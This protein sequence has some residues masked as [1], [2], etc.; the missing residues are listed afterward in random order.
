MKQ[1]HHRFRL[2]SLKTD[3]ASPTVPE[4]DISQAGFTI[5]ELLIA[6]LV[7][8]M[9]II[10]ILYGVLDFT[11]AYYSGV[12]S[13]STQDTAR[14]IMNTI[15]QSVEFSGSDI[16]TTPTT[17]P[18]A[19]GLVSFCAGGT[20]YV[21]NWGVEYDAS[22]GP[23]STNAGLYAIAGGCQTLPFAISGGQE[24]LA[25]HM[26]ITYL[27]VTQS[28]ANARL[29]TI[30]LGLAYGGG[31][32]LCNASDTN[33]PGGCLPGATQNSVSASVVGNS[34]YADGPENDVQCLRITG[35]QFCARAGLSTTVSLR[36]ANSALN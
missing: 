17:L 5:I 9:V 16:T 13:S 34:S 14:N 18:A 27:S 6:T 20:T 31:D 30:T 29:Y 22:T 24:L 12:N 21:Y 32:L 15:A 4:P 33:H 35:S 23:S 25:D 2:L 11:H 10:V 1:Y 7:F 28:P 3:T 8:S 36:V 26:R 19:G